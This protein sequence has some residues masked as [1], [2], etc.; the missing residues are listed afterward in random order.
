MPHVIVKAW[1]GKSEDQKTR[2]AE[3]I[4]RNVMEIF[5]YGRDPVSVA[6]EEVPAERWK[7]D[8]YDPDI[9]AFPE[10]LYKKPGY[11]M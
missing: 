7:E 4:T 3:A 11:Q 9:E 8:V 6:I 5:D 10:R 1:P 2:L